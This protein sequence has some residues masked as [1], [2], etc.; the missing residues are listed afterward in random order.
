[1]KRESRS[2]KTGTTHDANAEPL[3]ATEPVPRSEAAESVASDS[4]T[5]TS[6]SIKGKGEK[7]KASVSSIESFKVDCF[8]SDAAQSPSNASDLV[9]I[10]ARQGERESAHRRTAEMKWRVSRERGRA[11]IPSPKRLRP[12]LEPI[13]PPS[14][15]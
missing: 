11:Q 3:S 13:S 1:M 6:P 14:R 12:A 4:N 9:T 7:E 5:T 15:V 2:K 8:G 10:L